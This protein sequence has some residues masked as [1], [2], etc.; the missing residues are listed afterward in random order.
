MLSALTY[1][2][3]NTLADGLQA[4]PL[5][6]STTSILLFK[7][8]RLLL[9][10]L[11]IFFLLCLTPL[12]RLGQQR[13]AVRRTVLQV[14]NASGQAPPNGVDG[15][16]VAVAAGG[17]HSLAL[18]SD[19]TIACWGHNGDGQAPPDGVAGDFVAIAAG[20]THSLAIR[21]DG[22]IACW[23]ANDDGQVPPDGV[24]GEFVAIAAIGD[25][26]LAIRRDGNIAFWG[27]NSDGQA[28]P[29]GMQ[30]DCIRWRCDTTAASRGG[31][32]SATT[33]RN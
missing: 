7:P 4:P 11:D 26:S 31:G 8:M 3:S 20:S 12:R 32:T 10:S 17:Y 30:G 14:D 23:G 33:Q 15:E 19:G 18:R 9:S 2:A 13:R 6:Y 22:T 28:P 27:Y 25:H 16:F 21:R 5:S 24:A 29:Q 1:L